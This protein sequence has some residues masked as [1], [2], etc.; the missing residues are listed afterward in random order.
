VVELGSW[1]VPPLFRL[2]RDAS[3]LPA[4]ELHRTLNMGIGMVIICAPTNVPALQSALGEETWVIGGVT[5]DPRGE[6]VLR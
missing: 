1:P 4:D 2:I 3:A 5:A 6:V